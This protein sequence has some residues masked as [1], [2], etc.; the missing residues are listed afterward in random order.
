[1][2]SKIIQKLY[3]L[4]A[5]EMHQQSINKLNGNMIEEKKNKQSDRLFLERNETTCGNPSGAK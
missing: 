1:M 5:M 4:C 2:K 3:T